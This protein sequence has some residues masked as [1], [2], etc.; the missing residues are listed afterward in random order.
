MKIILLG[1]GTVRSSLTARIVN[2]GREL[3]KRGHEVVLIAPR[4]DKYT[5]FKDERLAHIDGIKIIHPAQFTTHS[6]VLNF[7]PYLPSAAWHVWR[8]KGDAV[9]LYK[10]TPL[11][12]VGLISTL[13]RRSKVI[14]DMDDLGSQVMAREGN[15]RW[16]VRLVAATEQAA[17]KYADAVVTASSSLRDY[18][19]RQYPQKSVVWV[20]NGVA[21]L[22]LGT[23]SSAP[24][25]VFIGSLNGL[26][27]ITPLIRALPKIV[28]ELDLKTPVLQIIGDGSKR[29]DLIKLVQRQGMETLVQFSHTWV[30][31]EQLNQRIKVGALGYYCV[32]NEE[33]YIAA[34]S[35]KIF[36]YLSLGVIPVVNNVGDLPY[37]VDN[38]KSGY[39]IGDNLA[40]AFIAAVRDQQGRE[41]KIK[42]GRRY[43]EANFL[44]SVLVLKLEGLYA[45]QR[46]GNGASK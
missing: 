45:D 46:A 13:R 18:Y 40:A 44:W 43:L 22:D 36:S 19:Q 34:S 30:K 29:V 3:V 41:R 37:Y 6:Q 12:I 14:L 31:P 5:N 9:H 35:Q 20:P 15:A 39:I 27:V 26:A 11:T 32:P 28:D 24:P 42:A 25:I 33:T 7:I 4:C 23:A 17:A 21:S 8:Q 38:G 10:P 2:I 16:K 1:S